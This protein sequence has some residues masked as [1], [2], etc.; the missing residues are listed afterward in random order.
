MPTAVFFS[1]DISVIACSLVSVVAVG[2]KNGFFSHGPGDF[3]E[4]RMALKMPHPVFCA[5]LE[6]K[7][8]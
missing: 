5:I 2:N 3:F 1:Q 4:K 8:Y 7:G 6:F